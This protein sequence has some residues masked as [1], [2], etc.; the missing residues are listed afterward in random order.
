MTK[1]K[2]FIILLLGYFFF[3]GYLS[4]QLLNF[5]FRDTS[6]TM[7]DI[8]LGLFFILNLCI[9]IAPEL[10][11]KKHF[12]YYILS[13]GLILIGV[14]ILIYMNNN[15]TAVP[16]VY[17]LKVSSFSLFALIFRWLSYIVSVKITNRD[18]F[19]FFGFLSISNFFGEGKKVNYLDIIYTILYFSSLTIWYYFLSI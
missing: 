16:N 4:F 8:F 15:L 12:Q 3:F 7:Q 1:I 2:P 9:V 5:D 11:K 17:L 18:V 19:L 13:T 14:I 6:Q 10:I